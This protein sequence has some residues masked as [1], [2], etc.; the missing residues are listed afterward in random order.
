FPV[1]NQR[2]RKQCFHTVC[3]TLA[4]LKAGLNRHDRTRARTE[5]AAPGRKIYAMIAAQVGGSAARDGGAHCGSNGLPALVAAASTQL[6]N[7]MPG[8]GPT[9]PRRVST[10]ADRPVL[11]A[12]WRIFATADHAFSA[13]QFHAHNWP[14]NAITLSGKQWLWPAKRA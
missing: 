1:P 4:P 2:R 13:E 9:T 5:I 3:K 10:A 7:S 11:A 14:N 6:G 8:S 12:C